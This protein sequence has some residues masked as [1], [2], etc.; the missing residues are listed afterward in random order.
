M[1]TSQ[2]TIA[3]IHGYGF[4]LRIW[5]PVELAF[6]G[7]HVIYLSLPGFGNTQLIGPYNMASLASH[8]WSELDARGESNVHLVG[9]SMG[10]Y[11]CM[12]MLAQQPSRVDSLCL[13]HSHVFADPE[14]KKKTRTVVLDEIKASGREGFA[15]RM[16]GSLVFDAKSHDKIIQQ[17]ITRGLEYDDDAWYYGTQAIRDRND[18]GETLRS[19]NRPCLMLMGDADPVVPLPLVYQQAALSE[20]ATLKVYPNVAHLSMYENTLTLIED[21]VSFYQS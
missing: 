20:R 9:H 16:I 5:S 15:R 21:L 19:F 3:L 8:F 14:E 4:D 2:I 1:N 13:V 18:H 10:G 12:E 11:A 17:L 7:F 6:N